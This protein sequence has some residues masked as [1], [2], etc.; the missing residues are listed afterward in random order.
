MGHPISLLALTSLLAVAT[1][2]LMCGAAGRAFAQAGAAPGAWSASDCAI[3]HDKAVNQNFQH[4]AHGKGD[5][6][7]ATCHKNVAEHMQRQLAGEKGP[8]P[9][10]KPLKVRDV[11]DTCL[12]CHESGARANW[13]GGLHD[14]R[15]TG[16]LSCHSVHNFPVIDDFTTRLQDSVDTV[17]ASAVYTIVPTKVTL[18]LGTR[19][20]NLKDTAAFTTQPN[21]TYQLARASYGGV[22]DIPNADN[23]KMV[24]LDASVD[25]AIRPNLTLT[26]DTWYEDYQLPD[27]DSVG[28]QNIYP[29]AF[30]LAVNDGGYH[31]TVGYVRLTYHW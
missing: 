11:N 23:V 28:L 12:T 26:A 16:C 8:T 18:N 22:Q 9:S 7:C 21:S 29:G 3:C 10:L 1:A 25:Y 24:R 30:F 27:V 6:S 15:D 2:I 13:H 14:R 31:A 5:Q 4:S 19:Y 20:Q 17:G